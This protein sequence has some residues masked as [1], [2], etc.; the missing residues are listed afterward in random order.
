METKP[1][2]LR[3]L[4]TTWLMTRI[5]MDS[6][7]N[8]PHF[9]ASP[10]LHCEQWP[11]RKAASGISVLH[12]SVEIGLF[13]CTTAFFSISLTSHSSRLPLSNISPLVMPHICMFFRWFTNGASSI[14]VST[15]DFG[16]AGTTSHS[17]TFL[18]MPAHIC[19]FLPCFI[20]LLLIGSFQNNRFKFN[21]WLWFKFCHHFAFSGVLVRSCLHSICF[22][23]FSFP[24]ASCALVCPLLSLAFT[25]SHL[26]SLAFTDMHSVPLT[27]TDFDFFYGS[28]CFLWSLDC[29]LTDLYFFYIFVGVVNI[30]RDWCESESISFVI[31]RI[32]LYWLK[33]G[34]KRAEWNQ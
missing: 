10:G 18:V 17:G 1:F 11:G 27:L 7:T 30:D 14:T 28:D 34:E 25:F 8:T 2:P 19:M 16:F 29:V 22:H 4:T 3:L 33:L 32:D 21:N 6:E 20:D 13:V 15:I 26:L 24:L 12:G 31:E 23:S 5:R 9:P